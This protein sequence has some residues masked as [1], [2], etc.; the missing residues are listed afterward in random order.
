M[1][2]PATTGNPTQ[3]AAVLTQ[4]ITKR[5]N[6]IHQNLLQT[7]DPVDDTTL[8]TAYNNDTHLQQL[9]TQLATWNPRHRQNNP[10]TPTENRPT[11]LTDTTTGITW[12]ASTHSDGTH[13]VNV[14][15]LTHHP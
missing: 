3:S 1:I 14:T 4:A 9:H 7:G 2:F 6:Q 12:A 11:L 13:C 5:Q 8:Q 10:T 15:V